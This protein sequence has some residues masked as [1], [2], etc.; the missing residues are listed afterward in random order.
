MG[1]DLVQTSAHIGARP[2]HQAWQGQIF[3]RSGTDKRYPDFV[4]ATGYGTVTGLGGANCRHSYYP[5]F[6]GISK[7][8]Y[9]QATRNEYERKTV[10]Y[11][12]NKISAYDASQIQRKHERTIR[13]WKRQKMGLEAGGYDTTKESAKVREWQARLRDFIDKT[14][15][16]RQYVRERV[17]A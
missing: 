2:E 13:Y 6:K 4:T 12:G 11:N 7:N 10:T 9:D 5:Y 17:I 14:K 16:D 3:S 8:A 1:V 15:L